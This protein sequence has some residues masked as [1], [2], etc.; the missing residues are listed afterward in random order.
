MTN[1]EFIE[2]I[3]LEGE[4][5]REIPSME[6][7]YMAS[8]CGR[9]MSMGRYVKS[10]NNS[11]KLNPPHLMTS[12]MN[13]CGYMQVSI[14]C[15][16]KHKLCLVH[17]LVAS[18]FIPKV[19]GKDYVDHIDT[20]KSNNNANNLRWCTMSENMQ[21]EKTVT[22][23]RRVYDNDTRRKYKRPVVAISNGIVI[24]TYPSIKSVKEDGHSPDNVL[25]ACRHI[26]NR[27][28]HHNFEWMY[29]SD[30]EKSLVNQ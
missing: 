22:Q 12:R 1:E 7:F 20:C 21:N 16:G 24:K 19:D 17:R 15:N 29:L 3:R 9:I 23:L 26:A 30:Y 2:S 27:R 6:G 10:K 18:A 14:C 28:R 5:W 25:Q 8:T 13:K 11:I 4:E